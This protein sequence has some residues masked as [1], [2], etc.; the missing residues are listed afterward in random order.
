VTRTLRLDDDVDAALEK[1]AE[2]RG[3]SV[4]A[5]AGRALRKLVEWD[6][7]AENAGLVIVSSTTMGRLMDSQTSEQARALGEFVGNEVW[8]PVIISR[9]GEVTLDSVLKSIELIARYMGRFDFVYSTEGSKRVVTIRHSG[10]IKWS[11]FYLGVATPLFSQALGLNINPVTTEELVS[12]E[13]EVQEKR[14]RDA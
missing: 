14:M 2:E 1:M 6:R 11:E 9:Y 5:I 7:L 3:E 8:K 12:I 10:G 4:N 13:F